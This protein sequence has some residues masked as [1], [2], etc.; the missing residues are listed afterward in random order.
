VGRL[1]GDEHVPLFNSFRMMRGSVARAAAAVST[2]D[3]YFDVALGWFTNRVTSLPMELH[4]TRPDMAR[5]SGYGPR[6][7]LSHARR[8]LISSD[9][10]ALR[11]GAS[12]GVTA[13]LTSLVSTLLVL[14]MWMVRPEFFDGVRGW[15]SLFLAILFF[16]G[17]TA[18]LAGIAVEYNA[19]L[20]RLAQGKP[21]FFVVDRSKDR[22]LAPLVER[23]G[24]P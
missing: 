7:L 11:I 16:G 19:T 4:D 22:L 14:G 2:H 3:T 23:D 12:I 10:K 13:L 20:L 8:M 5:G 18:L 6:A 1:A 24:A 17:M 21:T 9:V 15:L